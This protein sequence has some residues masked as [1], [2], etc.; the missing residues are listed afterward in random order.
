MSQDVSHSPSEDDLVRAAIA[1]SDEALA[2]LY[3][4]Y[5][6]L[7]YRAAHRILADA[8]DAEDVLH[9]VF[10]GLPEAL[11]RFERGRPLAPWLRRVAVRT[12]LM[13]IRARDRSDERALRAVDRRPVITDEPPV[14]DLI[15]LERVLARIPASL[16]VVLVLR[17]VE[18]YT[19]E[20]IGRLL[21]ISP[22]T[23]STRLHRAWQKLRRELGE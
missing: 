20:E 5:A 9:D 23:S 15:R 16:R 22:G 1:G 3:V 7:V 2:E 18:G 12:T 10:V 11:I 17:E 8:A 19:H 6:G 14:L 21:G 4:R 13:R